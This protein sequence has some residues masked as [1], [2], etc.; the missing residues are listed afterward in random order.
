MKNR[1][2]ILDGNAILHRAWHAMPPLTTKD[3][4]VVS[5]A[6]GFTVMLL[7]VLKD[8]KPPHIAVTFDLPGGTFRHEAFAE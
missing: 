5:A 3:G 1:F 4:R 6:Y 8:V 7:K 2:V